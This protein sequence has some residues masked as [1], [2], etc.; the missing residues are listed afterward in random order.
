MLVARRCGAFEAL[1]NKSKGKKQKQNHTIGTNMIQLKT[2]KYCVTQLHT[3]NP[4]LE[5]NH[6]LSH[7]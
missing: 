5:I 1:T 7:T 2:S 6:W 4:I 3:A